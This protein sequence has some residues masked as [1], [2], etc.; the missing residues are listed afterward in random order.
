M[1]VR[2]DHDRLATVFAMPICLALAKLITACYTASMPPNARLVMPGMP[3]QATQLGAI[4]ENTVASYLI[5]ASGG[6]ISPFKAVADDS[7]ID[8]LIYDKHTGRA[9][10][11]QVKCRTY[12]L[13]SNTAH[14]GVRLATFKALPSAFLLAILF[15]QDTTP[16][17]V[18]R[19]WLIP[20]DELCTV[21]HEIRDHLVIRPCV[22]DTSAD[23]YTDY[24]YPDLGEVARRLVAWFDGKVQDTVSVM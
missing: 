19:A 17:T 18:Q 22:K 15:A 21:A 13:H 14:F 24:R 3:R 23:R 12:T 1:R 8:L 16:L 11:V 20:T 7:G 4:G 5:L 6:R 10:P 9:V 2:L